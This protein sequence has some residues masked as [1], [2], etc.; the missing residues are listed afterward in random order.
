[1]ITSLNNEKVKK[2]ALLGKSA[3]ARREADVFLVEGI[4]MFKEIPNERIQEVFMTDKFY[5]KNRETVN[6]ILGLYS[7][8]GKTKPHIEMVS[9]EVYA[10]MSDTV[11][12]Q[13]ILAVVSAIHYDMSD[14]KTGDFILMLENIQDPGNLGTMFRTAEAAGVSGIV[15]SKETVNVYNPKVIRSTM[16]SI[17]RMPFIYVED[18]IDSMNELKKADFKIYAAA[19]DGA[20]KYNEITYDNKKVILIGN[21]G[22]GL[23][24]ETVKN[25]NEAVY[26]PMAGKV[27]SLNASI[28]AAIL[29][30]GV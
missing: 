28:S 9:E 26:I 7:G 16:G 30:Y 21:E 13:G 8:N 15:M 12:P 6:E 14:I 17:F 1:M 24:P 3:K 10:K 23:K 18:I 22:N 19:L 29:L 2:V 4:R 20:S 27:E 11:T 5:E 25:A